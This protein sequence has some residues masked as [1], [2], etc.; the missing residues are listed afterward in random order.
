MSTYA[1]SLS[2]QELAYHAKNANSISKL[3]NTSRQ[4]RSCLQRILFVTIKHR[5]SLNSD[6]ELR[7]EGRPIF[8]FC[9][10]HSNL[11]TLLPEIIAHSPFSKYRG[12]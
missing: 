11:K 1:Q 6:A 9:K 8:R 2:E 3:S 7:I 5:E 4:T 10:A 12:R